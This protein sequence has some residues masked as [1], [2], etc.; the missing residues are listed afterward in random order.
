VVVFYYAHGGSEIQR[1]S[2]QME[3]ISGRKP[4]GVLAVMDAE[5]SDGTYT[6]KAKAFAEGLSSSRL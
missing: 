3:A 5:V 6:S 4:H 1:V 2:S